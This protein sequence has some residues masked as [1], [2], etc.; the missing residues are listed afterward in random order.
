M[1]P[2]PTRY[3][4]ETVTH[5]HRDLRAALLAGI[6]LTFSAPPPLGLS[7]RRVTAWELDR[8][9]QQLSERLS[10]ERTLDQVLDDP[11][12]PVG[13]RAALLVNA[14]TAEMSLVLEGLAT[15]RLTRQRLATLLRP[16]L[17]YLTVV[18]CV[19]AIFLTFFSGF[20]IPQVQFLRDDMRL[21]PMLLAPTRFDATAVRTMF[22]AGVSV[23]AFISLV[24]WSIGGANQIATWMGGRRYRTL[25]AA[26][27]A[28]RAAGVLV[29]H[30][31]PLPTAV[32]WACGLVGNEPAVRAVVEA[33]VQRGPTGDAVADYL[34]SQ[35]AHLHSRSTDRLL[36]MGWTL[37]TLLVCGLGGLV[38]FAY[39]LLVLW[40][41]FALYKDLALPAM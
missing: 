36:T 5:F 37:P 21:T 16:T 3:T 38:V 10:V 4:L 24:A 7:P 30:A 31:V 15:P 22:A 25:R 26:A 35:A 1:P 23:L 28:V 19:A 17:M 9:E 41:V 33:T 18:L 20:I 11:C 2:E 12:F 6:P 13:Y 27:T 40:P 14:S 32:G 8:L 39:S 29:D 34:H